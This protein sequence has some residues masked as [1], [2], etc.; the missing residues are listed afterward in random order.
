M[1]NDDLAARADRIRGMVALLDGPAG[2]SEKRLR[3]VIQSVNGLANQLLTAGAADPAL[4]AEI[5]AWV[6]RFRAE[7]AQLPAAPPTESVNQRSPLPL[8]S[9]ELPEQE[10]APSPQVPEPRTR[11][12]DYDT[13]DSRTVYDRRGAKKNRWLRSNF[14]SSPKAIE[15]SQ[16][17]LALRQD[18][19]EALSSPDTDP[20]FLLV[21]I[22]NLYVT[23]KAALKT[24]YEHEVCDEL[25]GMAIRVAGITAREAAAA[26]RSKVRH[27]KPVP[28]EVAPIFT[29]Q[30][31]S[32]GLPTLGRGRR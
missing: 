5:I 28:A 21:R 1:N 2:R 27:H 18:V 30:V 26:A 15:F 10:T 6:I 31:V 13:T 23:R 14:G 3:A 16:K 12:F 25:D 11:T 19:E 4:K 22:V 9:H 32:G 7:K 29:R 17:I 20:S 24:N 8:Q